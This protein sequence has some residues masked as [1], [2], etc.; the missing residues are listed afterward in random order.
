ME[1]KRNFKGIW[2]PKE[3]WL[4]KELSIQE[5]VMLVEIDSLEDEIKGCW[6]SNKYFAEFF[7][8]ST[9]RIAEIISSLKNKGYIKTQYIYKDKEIEQRFIFLQ[10]PPYPEVVKDSSLGGEEICNT[11][12]EE[13]FMGGSEENFIE[14]NIYL[15]NVNINNNNNVE[16]LDNVP[17]QEIIS[18]L[19]FGTGSNYKH[20]TQKTKQ[21]IK[22]R[23]NEG[24]KVDDFKKVI[25]NMCTEWLHNPKMKCYLRPETLFG[26]KFESYLNRNVNNLPEWVNKKIESEPCNEEELKKLEEMF[27]NFK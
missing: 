23:Y 15:N 16:N 8:L 27:K 11:C 9:R 17:Y 21:L 26:T 6:A 10:R 5:K 24:F 3:I 25:D 13:N 14:N 18:Y 1:T 4:S 12:G 2:I 19:N 7:K 22:A 20:T